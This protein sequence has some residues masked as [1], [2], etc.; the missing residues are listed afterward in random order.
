VR[1]LLKAVIPRRQHG[2]RHGHPREDT[3]EEIARIGRKDVG[4]VGVGVR[5]R[6]GVVECEIKSSSVEANIA[7]VR[8]VK[9]LF[10]RRL[11]ARVTALC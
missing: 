3:R 8:A 11:V 2:H 6:V 7:R 1:T 9:E 10:R 5:V 4:R